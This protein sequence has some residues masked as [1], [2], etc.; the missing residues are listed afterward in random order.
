MSPNW[1]GIGDQGTEN[2]G[3]KRKGESRLAERELKTDRAGVAEWER[4]VACLPC[5]SVLG[6]D[7]DFGVFGCQKG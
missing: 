3:R 1:S 6:G 5:F 7:S 4:A 2:G